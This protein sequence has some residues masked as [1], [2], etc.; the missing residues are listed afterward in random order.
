MLYQK[1]FTNGKEYCIRKLQKQSDVRNIEKRI[2]WQISSNYFN[3]NIKCECIKQ[4]N[5][6][7]D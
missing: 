1:P 3:N 5:Q 2:K 7:T 6:K 4:S